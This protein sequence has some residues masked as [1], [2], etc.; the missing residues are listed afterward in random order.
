MPADA[1]D[2]PPEVTDAARRRSEARAARDWAAADALRE[3][4]EAAGWRVVDSGTAYRLEPAAAPDVE[5][6]G[7]IRYGRSEAVPSRLGEPAT[8]LASVVL[9]A[10]PDPGETRRVLDAVTASAPPGVDVVLV[11]D[12]LPDRALEGVRATGRTQCL[13]VEPDYDCSGGRACHGH[14]PRW[15]VPMQIHCT[16]GTAPIVV[17]ERTVGCMRGG[18][19]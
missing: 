7:E 8:G 5:V 13:S 16:G 18:Y 6:G 17:D 14:A 11:A 9:V 12:G 19:P 4:I 2:A 3:E 15:R 10:S 1:R